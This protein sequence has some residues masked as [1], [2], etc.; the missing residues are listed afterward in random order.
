MISDSRISDGG[1]NSVRDFPLKNQLIH[2]VKTVLLLGIL[3]LNACRLV[4]VTIP[5]K[6]IPI[7]TE[8]ENAEFVNKQALPENP[9]FIPPLLEPRIENGEKVFDLVIQ[10]GEMEFFPGKRTRTLGYNGD[11]LGPTLRARTG[12]KVRL[13][14]TNALEEPTTTHWHG[15]RVPAAMDGGPHQTI[16]ASETWQPHWTIDNEAATLWYHPH[17]MGRTGEQVYRGLAGFFILEDENSDTLALPREYGVDDIPLVVQDREFDEHAQLVYRHPER[18][19]T[20]GMLGDT[21]LVNG[22]YAPYLEVPAKLIRLRLLNGSNARRYNFGFTD[23]RAFYQIASDGGLLESPVEKTRIM[24]APGE[25]AEIL[26]DLRR[27]E[28]PVTLISYP[29]TDG[30]NAI[31]NAV[32]EA[33]VGQTDEGQQFRILELRPRTGD[34]PSEE[35]PTVLNAIER[36]EKNAAVKTRR[37]TLQAFT[38]NSQ[39]MDPTRV[40][41][42]VRMDD[43]EIWELFND[44]PIYHPFHIHGVQFLILDRNGSKPSAYEQSWK[45]TVIV[46][47][48]ETVRVILQFKDYADPHLPYMFHCHILEHEDMGMMGQFVVVEDLSDEVQIQSPLVD[49]KHE[50][51]QIH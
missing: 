5:R 30:E 37:F 14:V 17:L 3:L 18:M 12:D 32:Q 21:I 1:V 16:Q 27:S 43:I 45:D 38:I 42:V 28:E 39:L 19:L 26:V 15:M 49:P 40:D 36:L 10:E 29:F 6:E 8:V 46:L 31:Q 50:H 34:V 9:L 20:S 11:Y 24:L 4:P 23:N 7:Y 44:S 13:N 35:I 47:P 41:Q 51:S 48:G 22:T 2:V 33:L 25:R